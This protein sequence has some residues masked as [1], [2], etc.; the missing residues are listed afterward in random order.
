MAGPSSSASRAT[1][2][3]TTV[4]S[5][6]RK[7][8]SSQVPNRNKKTKASQEDDDDHE[9]TPRPAVNVTQPEEDEDE[10]DGGD[11]RGDNGTVTVVESDSVDADE[12][13][14]QKQQQLIDS[15]RQQVKM[16]QRKP[17]T[18]MS[19]S[20]EWMKDSRLDLSWPERNMRIPFLGKLTTE[21]ERYVILRDKLYASWTQRG[22]L[23]VNKY[24]SKHSDADKITM[25]LEAHDELEWA[26]LEFDTKLTFWI[27]EQV[28]V[29]HSI[30]VCFI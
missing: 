20:K 18:R 29:R 30:C 9:E 24:W 14:I 6:N 27:C 15:L 22:L 26:V 2:N 21:E 25:C 23:D 3:T 12:I 16:L 19:K 10:D 1:R 8:A 5:K 13:S 7:P 11:Q 17:G 28:K 4:S